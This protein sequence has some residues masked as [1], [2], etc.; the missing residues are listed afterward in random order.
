MQLVIVRGSAI[1]PYQQ[2]A[3]Q[4]AVAIRSGEL[5]PG[6]RIPTRKEL[7]EVYLLDLAPNTVQKAMDLLKAEGL[8]FTSPGLGLF[9]KDTAEQSP[10]G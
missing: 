2:L 4:I 7:V 1:P 3:E 5:A 8:I 10:A 6:D 9:V